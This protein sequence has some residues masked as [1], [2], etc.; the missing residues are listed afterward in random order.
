MAAVI[1]VEAAEA[2]FEQR[3]DWIGHCW[4]AQ[5]PLV[6]VSLCR[7]VESFLTQPIPRLRSH[8][9]GIWRERGGSSCRGGLCSFVPPTQLLYAEPRMVQLC[10]LFEQC[11]LDQNFNFHQ[12]AFAV[13]QRTYNLGQ[14]KDHLHVKQSCI[15]ELGS[16]GS[17][18]LHHTNPTE[19]SLECKQP[20][21]NIDQSVLD[22]KLHIFWFLLSFLLKAL[23][24]FVLNAVRTDSSEEATYTV[25]GCVVSVVLSCWSHI[26]FCRVSE[27]PVLHCEEPTTHYTWPI[28]QSVASSVT[29]FRN[30]VQ[31]AVCEIENCRISVAHV[32]LGSKTAVCVA[33]PLSSLMIAFRQVHPQL[34]THRTHSHTI[35][36]PR[37]HPAQETRCSESKKR[38]QCSCSLRS[39]PSCMQH[40]PNAQRQEPQKCSLAIPPWTTPQPVVRFLSWNPSFSGIGFWKIVSSFKMLQDQNYNYMDDGTHGAKRQCQSAAMHQASSAST[41]PTTTPNT[42][43]CISLIIGRQK[44]RQKQPLQ[45][46][47]TSV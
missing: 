32:V 5:V 3:T 35:V 46:Y 25:L 38:L 21:P 24:F 30:T 2:L 17:F 7:T 23:H 31:W 19:E 6:E 26:C 47:E 39:L 27:L 11:W 16:L 33:A 37:L 34:C 10:L 43:Q 42:P 12:S 40:I 44:C 28:E 8:T 13:N 1:Q 20:H 29:L 45:L 4:H 15:F 14:I 18:P 22:F 41:A 9:S 36:D